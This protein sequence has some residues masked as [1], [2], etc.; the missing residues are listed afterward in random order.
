MRKRVT[1]N[2]KIRAY[3]NHLPLGP[4]PSSLVLVIERPSARLSYRE[5]LASGELRAL[6]AAQLVSVGGLSTAAVA[7][8]ILVYRRTGSPLLASL[9]FAVSFLPYV[10]GAGLLSGLVDPVRPRGLVF[11]CDSISALLMATIAWPGLPLPI[12]FALLLSGGMLSSVSSGARAALVRASVPTDAYVPARSLLRIAAQLA[13]I[14]GNAG[15]GALLVVLSPSGALLVSAATFLLS[16]STIRLAV[17]DHPQTGEPSGATLLRDSLRGAR[18]V[19]AHSELRT[20][21]LLGWLAP[22][23]AV[24]PEALAAPYVTGHHGSSAVVGWW[25]VALPIGL[26]AGDFAGVRLLNAQQQRRLVGPAAALGFVPYL[27]FIVNPPIPAAMGLLIVS[28]ACGLYVLGLDARVRDAAPRRLF[29][30]T[31]TLS[32]GGLMALQ[33]IGFTLAGAIGQAVG[34]AAAIAIAGGCGL[35]IILGLMHN[36][37]RL[38][39]RL[40]GAAQ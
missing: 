16:A 40:S 6:L 36:D 31:M 22:M 30:R 26:I 20:L 21:L 11:T 12:L 7:L 27:A 18:Q 23:F 28:G 10:L 37:L 19:L 15:G 24:A 17:T 35:A 32:S 29:A 2:R 13:Q 8:T 39:L 14:V 5:A 3:A 9:T 38:P 34:P 4:N 33:G 25:L 1:S